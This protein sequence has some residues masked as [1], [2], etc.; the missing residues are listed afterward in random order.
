MKERYGGGFVNG[1]GDESML[2]RMSARGCTGIGGSGI[3]NVIGS[4]PGDF[5]Q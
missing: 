5:K 2:G 3:T 4:L 1:M